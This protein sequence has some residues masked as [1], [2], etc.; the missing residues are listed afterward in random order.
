MDVDPQTNAMSEIALALSMAFFSIMVLT[1]VSMGSG[2]KELES[3]MKEN[4]PQ[5]TKPDDIRLNAKNVEND[6]FR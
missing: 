2:T 3:L 4:S 6:E 1:I 5:L